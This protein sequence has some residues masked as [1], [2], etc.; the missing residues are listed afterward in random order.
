M[1]KQVL[2]LFAI[3]L[4]LLSSCQKT[5]LATP[6]TAISTTSAD[7]TA[8]I[9]ALG[10]GTVS[11]AHWYGEYYNVF[12]SQGNPIPF[13]DP[14]VPYTD[15][16][17]ITGGVATLPIPSGV[18][19]YFSDVL[20]DIP[21][22]YSI[23]GDSIIYEVVIKNTNPAGIADYDV[24]LTLVGENKS[25]EV[26]FV[27]HKENQSATSY[28]LGT[29]THTNLLQ[30][31]SDFS[32]FQTVKLG[33]KKGKTGVYVN[34]KLLYQFKYSAADKL[35]RISEIKVGGKGSA[36]VDNVKLTNSYT[37]KKLMLEDFNTEGQSH[38]IFY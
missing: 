11:D 38:T 16:Q 23:P 4:I 6:G 27:A 21:S 9:A 26:H 8:G 12:D 5:E 10:K 19:S 18:S 22:Q 31:V 1:T 20:F 14:D 3:V 32:S 29:I 13:G 37:N 17:F 15:D 24:V 28:T 33:T 25:A 35:G 2:P 36:V 30:L 34:N 7:K